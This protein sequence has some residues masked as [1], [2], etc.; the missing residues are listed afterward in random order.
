MESNGLF[1]TYFF[2]STR[3]DEVHFGKFAGYYLQRTYYFDVHPPLAK[4]MIAAVGYM[5]GFDGKYDFANIGDDY[6]DH[7]VPYI[8]L[9][10]LPAT[11]NVFCTALIYL[12]MKESGYSLIICVLSTAMY[13]FD[14]AMVTQNR[15]ILLDSMLVFYMLSTIYAYIRFRKL[16]HKSFSFQWWLWLLLTGFAMSMTVR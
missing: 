6:H 8:G 1:G 7:D 13:I 15:L 2:F 10:S 3:F 11:L 9:R 5:L 4:L 12:I 16:R 14:N